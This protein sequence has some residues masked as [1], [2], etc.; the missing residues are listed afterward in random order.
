MK[1]ILF[2]LAITL[3]AFGCNPQNP[4]QQ[5]SNPNLPNQIKS[6]KLG[7]GTVNVEI[8]NTDAMRSQGLSGR[9]ALPENNGM[10]FDFTRSSQKKPSFWMKNMFIPLDIIWIRG[11]KVIGIAKN[12]PPPKAGATDSNLPVYSPPGEIDYVLEVNAGWS[13]KHKVSTGTQVIFQ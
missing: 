7:T 8:A 2:G 3:M 11:G 5:N 13:D 10:L 1:K 6:A 12:A 9:P 4:S